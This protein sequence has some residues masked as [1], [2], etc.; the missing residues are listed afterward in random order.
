MILPESS[1]LLR[2]QLVLFFLTDLKLPLQPRTVTSTPNTSVF[3]G[4]HYSGDPQLLP[5]RD[6][7]TT[8]LKRPGKGDGTDPGSEGPV[9]ERQP[10]VRTTD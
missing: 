1:T 7:S 10:W 6:D 9:P 3:H 4:T 8:D 2:I 5:F